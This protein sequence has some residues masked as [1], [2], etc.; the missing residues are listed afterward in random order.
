MSGTLHVLQRAFCPT[1][2]QQ[3]IIV[4]MLQQLVFT[5]DA[6]TSQTREADTGRNG[7]D[8]ICGLC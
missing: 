4:S 2:G 5:L 8:Q 6:Q 3:A 7:T 1:D